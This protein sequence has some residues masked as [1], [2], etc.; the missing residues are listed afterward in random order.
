MKGPCLRGGPGRR[1]GGG[2]RAWPRARRPTRRLAHRDHAQ[3][4]SSHL[5]LPPTGHPP[6][7]EGYR[8]RFFTRRLLSETLPGSGCRAP[9]DRAN[10]VVRSASVTAC[11]TPACHDSM[12]EDAKRSVDSR[13]PTTLVLGR[14]ATR[15]GA[16]A[17]A[18]ASRPPP[19][20][21]G[22]RRAPSVPRDPARAARRPVPPDGT[23]RARGRGELSPHL[24]ARAVPARPVLDPDEPRAHDR[25][26]GERR[27]SGEGYEVTWF[28][29]RSSREPGVLPA[30]VG[31]RRSLSRARPP[32]APRGSQRTGLRAAEREAPRREARARAVQGA[33]DRSRLVG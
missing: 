28:T 15:R 20:T 8:V 33:S 29:A 17:R 16:E 26:G 13:P 22:S 6:K 27:R 30:R 32:H 14:A 24:R 9:E 5:P 3:R 4:G 10:Q 12:H 7:Q 31:P 11:D 19:E 2:P 1:A 25:R 18:A 21:P 23:P